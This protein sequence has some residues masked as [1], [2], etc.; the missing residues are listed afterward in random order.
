MFVE[1]F[2]AAGE[3]HV[4]TAVKAVFLEQQHLAAPV[5]IKGITL[6]GKQ[7]AEHAPGMLDR[8]IFRDVAPIERPGVDDLVAEAVDEPD[9]L[10]GAE[11][12]RGTAAGPDFR[13]M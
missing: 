8:E 12:D 9:G 6:A 13:Q 5:G 1:P 10:A 3:Q 4:V 11:R 7:I 2:V